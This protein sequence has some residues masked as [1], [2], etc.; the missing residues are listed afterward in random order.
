MP[1]NPHAD[2]TR[3]FRLPGHHVLIMSGPDALAFA[4]AQFMNDVAALADGQWQWNGWLTPKGRL[5]ALFA[6]LR[7]DAGTLWLMLPD[8]EPAGLAAQLQR[9]VFRSKLALAVPALPVAG[10]FAVP[11]QAHSARFSRLADGAIELDM[12]G[13]GGPRR[14]V[15]GGA[16]AHADAGLDAQLRWDQADLAHGLPRLPASQVEQWTPQQLSLD[17]LQAYSVKKGC[18]PG[19]E[20]VARTHFLGQAKRGLALLQADAPVATGSAVDADGRALGSVVCARAHMLLAVA[21]LDLPPAALHAD[22]VA[23]ARI[24]LLGGLAR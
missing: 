24:P 14:L 2:A 18:Y 8:A 23:L 6:L 11:R 13:D 22:G 12:G 9:Y 17:R 20:I 7:L 21:P 10:D 5:L 1:D 19:Q 16:S 4:Q 15:I 3:E